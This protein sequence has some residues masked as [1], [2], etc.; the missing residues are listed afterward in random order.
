MCDEEI[1]RVDSLRHD[2]RSEDDRT[3]L[4]RSY[5]GIALGGHGQSHQFR[6]G[7]V[8]R[9]VCRRAVRMNVEIENI[10]DGASFV[11][12]EVGFYELPKRCLLRCPGLFVSD[13]AILKGCND[14][15]KLLRLLAVLQSSLSKIS[16]FGGA[17]EMT[18]Q[19][20]DWETPLR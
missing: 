4:E 17:Y 6:F 10:E 12:A 3:D 8:L 11:G 7:Q 20:C 15:S 2:S 9:E 5:Q 1:C 18:F 19:G 14:A 13:G 16:S